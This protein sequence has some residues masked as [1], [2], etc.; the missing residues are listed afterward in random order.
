MLLVPHLV[1]FNSSVRELGVNNNNY[2]PCKIVLSDVASIFLT[3]FASVIYYN[4]NT[5]GSVLNLQLYFFFKFEI[6]VLFSSIVLDL[7]SYV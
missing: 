7:Y 3:Y 6:H 5:Y 1:K 4:D 2:K